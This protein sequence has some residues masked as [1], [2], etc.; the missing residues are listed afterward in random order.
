VGLLTNL[1]ISNHRKPKCYGCRNPQLTHDVSDSTPSHPS[2]RHL[3]AHT[4]AYSHHDPRVSLP[5]SPLGSTSNPG[6]I[7][8]LWKVAPVVW[9][10][11]IIW[12]CNVARTLY[13]DAVY[14]FLVGSC[15]GGALGVLG[16]V[17][18]VDEKTWGPLVWRLG[19]LWPVTFVLTMITIYFVCGRPNLCSKLDGERG[20][21]VYNS[22]Y[23][24]WRRE[25]AVLL[26]RKP[27][28]WLWLK[29]S[30]TDNFCCMI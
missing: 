16:A 25:G 3:S 9:W 15:V 22:N 24:G 21:E 10:T 26:R 8:L 27:R 2:D 5:I 18:I 20:E 13:R 12:L 29:M 19:A 11:T 6:D 7:I 14:V 23:A 1:Q 28:W 30:T 17:L 4:L